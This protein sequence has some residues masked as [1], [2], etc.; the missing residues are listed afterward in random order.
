M[1]KPTP[2]KSR[3]IREDFLPYIPM[4]NY[5][6]KKVTQFDIEGTEWITYSPQVKVLW[7]WTNVFD[8]APLGYYGFST[9]EDAQ[10]Y[11]CNYLKNDIVEFIDFDPKEDCK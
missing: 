11:L 9:L 3:L 5:R 6:I 10:R 7:W 2:P 4:K 8:G 1:D